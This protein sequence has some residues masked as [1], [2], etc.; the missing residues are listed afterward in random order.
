MAQTSGT[1][2]L[3]DKGLDLFEEAL[4]LVELGHVERRLV[5]E[6][7]GVR[8]AA[9]GEVLDVRRLGAEDRHDLVGLLLVLERLQVVGRPPA[10]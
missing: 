9:D 6:V 5:V 10:D 2:D 4:D 7:D 1:V 3:L 8:H